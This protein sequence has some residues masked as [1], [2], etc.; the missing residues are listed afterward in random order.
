M[1]KHCFRNTFHIKFRKRKTD[2]ERGGRGG[3]ME[4]GWQMKIGIH[5]EKETQGT[6]PWREGNTGYHGVMS[7]G[8]DISIQ[9]HTETERHVCI[10]IYE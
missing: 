3:Q 7:S 5:E 6:L 9:N 8:R 1:R 2:R 10:C 4:E